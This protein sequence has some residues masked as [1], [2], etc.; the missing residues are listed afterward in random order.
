MS[1]NSKKPKLLQEELMSVEEFKQHYSWLK[2]ELLTISSN[3]YELPQVSCARI[4][5]L[6]DYSVPGGKVN[7]GLT[8][9]HV[10]ETLLSGQLS[11]EQRRQLAVLGWTIEWMQASF[12]VSDDMMD[13]SLTRRGHPCWYLV[14]GVGMAAVNDGLL[15]LTQVELI[16]DRFL[17][18]HHLMNK[19]RK[20]LLETIYQTE[21]GQLLD[22]TT[23]PPGATEVDLDLYTIAR[24]QQIV[25]YKTAF[26]SFLAPVKLGLLFANFNDELV[27][28]QLQDILLPMGE[29]FQ[30]QDDV[31]DCYG[32]PE[33]IGKIGT[34]IEDAKCSWLVVQALDRVN[35]EQRQIIKDFYGK[36]DSNSVAKIKQVF[37][38]LN[39]YEVFQEYEDHIVKELKRKIALLEKIEIQQ[40]CLGLLAKIYKRE[41]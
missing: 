18:E 13:S 4:G 32:A 39:L 12:L 25:K 38:E 8:I 28:A 20:C 29:Y 2:Q 1:V 41:K 3:E 37:A 17:S 30:I 7:R 36:K 27:F 23:Q 26:Y 33:V 5:E 35:T 34:D 21:L 11:L 24:Y 14:K 10:G 9:V 16:L 22:L 15:L 19:M 31:L 40:I 6:L